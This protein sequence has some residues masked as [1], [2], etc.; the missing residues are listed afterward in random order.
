MTKLNYNQPIPAVRAIIRNSENKILI[1]KRDNTS[2]CEGCWNLPGGK[3]DF[4]DTAE[5]SVKKEI[6]EET[7]LKCTGANFLFYMNNLPNKLYNTH[8][9]TLFFECECEGE[10]EIDFNG[11]SSDYCWIDKDELN[12]YK[13]A[14]E[15]DKAIERYFNA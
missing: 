8:F 7:K 5:D 13:L 1:L 15:N 10:C 2:F 6:Y 12:D 11:E 14:F 9:L 3:V 4:G